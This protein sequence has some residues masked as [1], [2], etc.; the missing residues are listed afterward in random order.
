MTNETS[1][2]TPDE[3]VAEKIIARFIET[4]LL[5]PQYAEQAR[6]QLTAG[7]MR[8]EDWRLLA[9]NALELEK[10]QQGEK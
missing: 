9:E 7:K 3:H 6:T 10:R 8:S 4:G 1:Y 5:P 2:N